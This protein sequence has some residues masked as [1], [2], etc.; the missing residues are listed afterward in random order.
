MVEKVSG[1]EFRRA[2]AAEQDQRMFV[3][4]AGE[5]GVR[6]DFLQVHSTQRAAAFGGVLRRGHDI[7]RTRPEQSRVQFSP[8]YDKDE[9]PTQVKG[10]RMGLGAEEE[11]LRGRGACRRTAAANAR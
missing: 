3:S 7:V 11:D 6:H 8:L 1:G 5:V 2:F 4:H 10:E 9:R